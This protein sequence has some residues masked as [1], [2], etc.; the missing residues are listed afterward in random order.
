[1]GDHISMRGNNQPDPE[2]ELQEMQGSADDN[3]LAH[4]EN[5]ET[6]VMIFKEPDSD[7]MFVS[8]DNMTIHISE[9]AFYSLVKATQESAKKLLSV[10]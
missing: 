2:G 8:I 9:T 3:I 6:T 1:M 4:I 10:E 7:L 5:E